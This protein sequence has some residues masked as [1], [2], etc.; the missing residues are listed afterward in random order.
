MN[1]YLQVFYTNEPL[2]QSVKVLFIESLKEMALAELMEGKDATY[3]AKS[4][5][6]IEKAYEKLEVEFGQKPPLPDL[7]AS[8]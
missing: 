6:G 1:E 5:Q 3:L 8:R 2:A 4:V 7:N